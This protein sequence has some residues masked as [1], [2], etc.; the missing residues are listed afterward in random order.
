MFKGAVATSKPRF[1]LCESNCLARFEY[2]AEYSQKNFQLILPIN[3]DS[4]IAAYRGNSQKLQ[5]ENFHGLVG[6]NTFGVSPGEIT[7]SI[8]PDSIMR[9]HALAPILFLLLIAYIFLVNLYY[10]RNQR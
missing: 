7:L 1:K 3:Y 6:I 5:I 4:V 8:A 10:Q 9:L 2:S